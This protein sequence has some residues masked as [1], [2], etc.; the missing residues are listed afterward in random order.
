MTSYL[1]WHLRAAVSGDLNNLYWQTYEQVYG[2]EIYG[3]CYGDGR[4]GYELGVLD[5]KLG[6]GRGDMGKD[7]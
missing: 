4:Y 3:D 1:E 2:T 5:N 7:L 6:H